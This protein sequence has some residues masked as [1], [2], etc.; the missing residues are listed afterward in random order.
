MDFIDFF[1]IFEFFDLGEGS[2]WSILIFFD[3]STFPPG[4]EGLNDRFH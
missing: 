2:K 1:R 4:G 3:F